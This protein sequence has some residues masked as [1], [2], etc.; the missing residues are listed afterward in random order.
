MKK[1]FVLLLIAICV[2]AWFNEPI[3]NKLGMVKTATAKQS[4][5]LPKSNFI[6]PDP[7]PEDK[8]PPVCISLAEYTEQAKTNP[9]AY[10]L[11]L[12]CGQQ[13]EDRTEIDKL[14]NF[15]SHLKYE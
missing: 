8:K 4:Y 13:E 5:S 9:N 1:L 12:Q 7:V 6:L 10:N 14:M 2:I 11:L 15:F 3:M